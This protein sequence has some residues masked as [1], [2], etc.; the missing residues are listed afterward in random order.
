MSSPYGIWLQKD[1]QQ[2]Q[3]LLL[4]LCICN[5]VGSRQGYG[6]Y[7]IT[8]SYSFSTV[9]F[10]IKF[11]TL[12]F[13]DRICFRPQVKHPLIWAWRT[14]LG[15]ESSNKFICQAEMSGWLT[16]SFTWEQWPIPTV[17]QWPIP[18]VKHSFLHII[19]NT[20]HGQRRKCERFQVCVFSPL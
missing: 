5:S 1:I 15:A 11:E 18:T 12:C 7:V 16:H 6:A 14:I 20:R 9:L 8:H 13:G 10:Q 3:Y 17:K 4:K 19:L 2:I